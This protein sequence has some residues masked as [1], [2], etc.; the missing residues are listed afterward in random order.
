MAEIRNQNQG[1]QETQARI[2]K[3]ILPSSPNWSLHGREIVYKKHSGKPSLSA[4]KGQDISLSA[5]KRE[6]NQSSTI[7]NSTTGNSP[8]YWN[9]CS[10]SHCF[11][12][13]DNSRSKRFC[14]KCSKNIV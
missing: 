5:T 1:S 3:Y 13:C 9:C 4:F 8:I 6:T 14:F 12:K 10:S 11:K 2:Q 7:Y